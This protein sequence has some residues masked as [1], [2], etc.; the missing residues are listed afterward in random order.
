MEIFVVLSRGMSQLLRLYNTDNETSQSQQPSVSETS[1]TLPLIERVVYS[2]LLHN[3]LRFYFGLT[4]F[5]LACDD[6]IFSW[7]QNICEAMFFSLLWF[8]Q[9]YM[10]L[11]KL[12]A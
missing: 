11:N 9:I 12:N 10:D 2:V 1:D 3:I 7:C 6:K 5:P 4:W 8:T